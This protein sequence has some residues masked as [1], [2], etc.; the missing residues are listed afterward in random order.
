MEVDRA[1]SAPGFLALAFG[2]VLTLSSHSVGAVC[3]SFI[4]VTDGGGLLLELGMVEDGKVELIPV[5]G[6]GGTTLPSVADR[7]VSL[8]RPC[9]RRGYHPTE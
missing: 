9:N 6:V 7:P 8:A 4:G 2:L 5:T 1:A 3:G